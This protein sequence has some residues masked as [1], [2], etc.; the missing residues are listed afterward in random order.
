MKAANVSDAR[1]LS[2]PQELR[3]A[4]LQSVLQWHYAKKMSLPAKTQVSVDFK[5]PAPAAPASATKSERL[6]IA[7]LTPAV[8]VSNTTAPTILKTI[9]VSSLS[10]GLQKELRDKLARYEGQ[11]LGADVMTDLMRAITSVD[12]HLG[13]SMTR[14]PAGSTLRIG[15]NVTPATAIY[16]KDAPAAGEGSTTPQRIRVGG[17]VQQAML[18]SQPRP[19]YPVEAKQQ[20][21]QG[22]GPP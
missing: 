3:K 12:S 2:G 21:I 11:E 10:E 5:L 19:T 18:V 22:I 8:P 16:S 13:I 6:P 4:A 17:N 7:R 20:R 1:V 15:M 14:T 9:D